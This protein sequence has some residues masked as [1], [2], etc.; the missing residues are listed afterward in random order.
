MDG[1]VS[2][3]VCI[4]RLQSTNMTSSKDADATPPTEFITRQT[5]DGRFSFVDQA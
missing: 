1:E 2:C 3:L 5:V 4:G